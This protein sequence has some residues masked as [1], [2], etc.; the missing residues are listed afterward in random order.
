[1]EWRI[2]YSH[3]SVMVRGLEK[4]LIF[5]EAVKSADDKH[6][7]ILDVVVVIVMMY[8]RGTWGFWVGSSAD[9]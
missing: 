8:P 2:T 4:D 6:V 3:D 7:V 1:M 9:K 5:V